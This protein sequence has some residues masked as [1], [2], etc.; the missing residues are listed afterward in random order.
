MRS[1]SRDSRLDRLRSLDDCDRG[2]LANARCL[3]EGVDV[4]SLDAIAF[5]DPRG[6]Q[7]DI[8]QA[9]GRVIRR[10]EDKRLGTVILPVFFSD[11][12]D[13]EEAVRSSAFDACVASAG[14]TSRA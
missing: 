2:L 10:A 3:A 12:E 5:V 13:E 11:A 6:S 1:A 4:P 7:V 8:V 9:V 14:C